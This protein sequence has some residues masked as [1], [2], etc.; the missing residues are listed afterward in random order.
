MCCRG[1]TR[2]RSCRIVVL[3]ARQHW[4]TTHGGTA[5][6]RAQ[7]TSNVKTVHFHIDQYERIISDLRCEVDTLKEKLS[8]VAPGPRGR[9]HA[10]HG[11]GYE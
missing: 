5:G 9:T 8:K 7:V 6:A 1:N 2:A 4:S 11:Y 10:A 3:V